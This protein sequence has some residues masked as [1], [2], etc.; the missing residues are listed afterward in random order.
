MSVERVRRRKILIFVLAIAMVSSVIVAYSSDLIASSTRTSEVTGNKFTAESYAG[1]DLNATLLNNSLYGENLIVNPGIIFKNITRQINISAYYGYVAGDAVNVFSQIEIRQILYSST[2][3]PYT[4]L[5]NSTTVSYTFSG[6][7]A[8][9]QIPIQVNITKVLLYAEQVDRQL[10]IRFAG[11]SLVV[12]ITGISEIGNT[13]TDLNAS[14]NMSFNYDNEEALYYGQ[15]TNYTY[16]SNGGNH[17]WH[18][19]VTVNNDSVIQLPNYRTDFYF[20]SAASSV[21][22]VA[23]LS[24]TTYILLPPKKDKLTKFKAENKE[25]IV[26][27]GTPPVISDEDFL[28]D[29]LEELHRIALISGSPIMLYEANGLS[30]LYL[31]TPQAT[32]YM[33]FRTPK[34]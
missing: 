11:P 3:P 19:S 28:L 30:M 10:N 25:D 9:V 4:K 15:L 8:F 29:S 14:L 20:V 7:Q 6:A 13:V 31:K 24:L 26:R 22:F 23:L 12:N 21:L 34:S 16:I 2:T 1:L 33:K 17:Y 32:Y 18:S 27:I 5:L